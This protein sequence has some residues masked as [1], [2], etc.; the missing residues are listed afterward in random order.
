MSTLQLVNKLD[1]KIKS[2]IQ[3]KSWKSFV[4]TILILALIPPFL[5]RCEQ[6]IIRWSGGANIVLGADSYVPSDLTDA[7]DSLK[8][9]LSRQELEFIRVSDESDLVRL[10]HSL[11]RSIRNEWDLWADSRL[12]NWFNEMDIFHPDDMSAIIIKSLHRDLAGRPLELEEQIDYYKEYWAKVKAHEE[13]ERREEVLRQERRKKANLGWQWLDS[14]AV[15]V[16]LPRR[17]EGDDVWG[18]YPYGEGLIVV[19]KGYRRSFKR[20]WHDGIYSS[21]HKHEVR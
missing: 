20:Q 7:I 4:L 2:F 19:M 18:L 9:E 8:S 1:N 13:N 3:L 11:G 12:A 10:H 15:E 6:L 16:T 14:D 17:P 5:S 21:F